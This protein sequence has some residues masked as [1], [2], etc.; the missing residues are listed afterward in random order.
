MLCK[1]S[2]LSWHFLLPLHLL[3]HYYCHLSFV[4]C[5]SCPFLP[6][7]MAMLYGCVS[8]TLSGAELLYEI[9]VDNQFVLPLQW[10]KARGFKVLWCILQK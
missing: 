3:L 7:S 9:L 8:R 6:C 2:W 4:L 5:V 10:V 1:H